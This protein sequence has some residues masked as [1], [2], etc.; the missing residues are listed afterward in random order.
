MIK[1]LPAPGDSSEKETDVK[2]SQKTTPK[3]ESP[4]RRLRNRER[5]SRSDNRTRDSEVGTLT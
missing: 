2:A 1:R 5:P 4:A 3:T